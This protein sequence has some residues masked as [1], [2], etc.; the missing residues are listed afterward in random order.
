MVLSYLESGCKS[1]E[2]YFSKQNKH[3]KMS[4]RKTKDPM[5]GCC[6]FRH[7]KYKRRRLL[8]TSIK[9]RNDEVL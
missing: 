1:N 8:K 5:C 3:K 7:H 6:S 2:S 4:I 9:E